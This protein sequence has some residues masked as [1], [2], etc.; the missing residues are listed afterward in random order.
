[1]ATEQELAHQTQERFHFYSLG[2][3]FTLLAASIQTGKFDGPKTA[4]AIELVGWACLLFAG[5]MLMWKVEW[6]STLR[7]LHQRLDE[8]DD[9]IH[10]LETLLAQGLAEADGPHGQKIN[11]SARLAEHAQK[12]PMARERLEKLTELDHAKYGWAKIGFVVGL[13]AVAVARGLP[14][15]VALFGYILH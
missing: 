10:T 15:A 14:H 7:M 11:I 1:M 12:V 13:I 5:L 6:D 9:E 3:I 8:A 4:T 2:L